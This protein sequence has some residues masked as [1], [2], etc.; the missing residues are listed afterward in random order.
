MPP[1]RLPTPKGVPDILR[2]HYA[3]GAPSGLDGPPRIPRSRPFGGCDSLPIGPRTVSVGSGEENGDMHESCRAM[4]RFASR[5][6]T[7]CRPVHAVDPTDGGHAA[8]RPHSV[9]AWS[10]TDC[11]YLIKPDVR[12]RERERKVGR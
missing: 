2:M 6:V 3:A 10:G 11:A 7:H 8:K 5:Q 9:D 1:G 12:Q 4:R